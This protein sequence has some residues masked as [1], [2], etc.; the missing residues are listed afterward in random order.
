MKNLLCACIVVLGIIFVWGLA[1][2]DG[3]DR[4]RLTKIDE[5]HGITLVVSMPD[6]SSR[7]DVLHVIGCSAEITEAGVFCLEDGW[8]SRSDRSISRAIEPIPFHDTPR[9]TVQ[10]TAYAV[11]RDAKV[12]ASSQLTLMRGF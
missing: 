7:Y 2:G 5:K 3:R 6:V 1:F 12:L 9:G 4:M 10:F 8:S 11:D